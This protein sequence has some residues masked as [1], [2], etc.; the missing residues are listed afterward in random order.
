MPSLKKKESR[1][2][3]VRCKKTTSCEQDTPK[4]RQS[5]L[6]RKVRFVIRR[7]SSK[8][9]RDDFQDTTDH[10]FSESSSSDDD[11]ND[12]I[13]AETKSK[14]LR[15]SLINPFVGPFAGLKKSCTDSADA[16]NPQKSCRET[17]AAQLDQSFRDIAYK[18]FRFI[19]EQL[20]EDKEAAKQEISHCFYNSLMRPASA[21]RML[22][23]R[24]LDIQG[25]QPSSSDSDD[26]AQIIAS[27]LYHSFM[28]YNL[29]EIRLRGKRGELPTDLLCQLPIVP[30]KDLKSIE[31]LQDFP[32]LYRETE[33]ALSYVP[34]PTTQVVVLEDSD[35]TQAVYY[36]DVD[37]V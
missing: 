14:P 22:S 30:A 4:R 21:V 20:A 10:D 35:E 17:S 13:E 8:Y 3:F 7:R 23:Q 27:C 6:L 26:V 9:K 18:S 1:L 19:T 28:I 34:E 25:S 37:T 2:S 15:P 24:V 29:T 31:D 32:K 11:N 5:S 33:A 12:D 36:V 16:S